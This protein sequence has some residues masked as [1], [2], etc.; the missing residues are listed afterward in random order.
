M[1]IRQMRGLF[2]LYLCVWV[3]SYF[4][5]T[6]LDT[7][8]INK[9]L[10]RVDKLLERNVDSAGI[11][12][13]H[14]KDLCLEKNYDLGAAKSLLQVCRYYTLK[15][16]VDSSLQYLPQAIKLAHKTNDTT[17]IITSYLFYARNLATNSK[18]D[19]AISQALIAQKFSENQKNLKLKTKVYHD[20]GFIHSAMNLH[21]KAIMYFEKGLGISKANKDTFNFANISARLGGEFHYVKLY[22]SS[23]Y[24]NLQGLTY[25]KMLNHKRGIGASMVNLASSYSA[26]HQTD[27][28]IEITKEAIK[29]RIE[30]GDS[31]AVTMLK[32]NLTD[33]YYDKQDYK[34]ALELAK[35]CEILVKEQNESELIIQ[36]YNSLRKIYRK[37]N[38][39]ELAYTYSERYIK[40]KD[41]IFEAANFKTLNELQAKYESEKNEREIKFLQAENESK[42]QQANNERKTRNLMVASISVVALLIGIFTLL[43][44]KRFK[45]T[46]RQ[47]GIIERQKELVDEK[48]REVT[49]S[50]NYAL[51]IQQAVIPHENDL[52]EGIKNAMVVFK[53]K[54]IVSGDFYW[55]SKINQYIFYVV[56]DCTGH[57]VPGAFMSLM[58]INY[59]SEIINEKT[60]FE[61]NDILDALRKKVIVNLNKT[62]STSQKRDGMDLAIFRFNTETMQVQ[63]S[64]ANNAIYV[65]QDGELKELKGDKMP[66]G[67]HSGDD[68]PFTKKEITLK[69]GDRIFSFTDGL[70]DQF[71][72]PKGKK[73]MYK[74]VEKFILQN[75]QKP[76]SELKLVI[77]QEFKSWKGVLEQVDDITFLAVQV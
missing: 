66:I 41:S 72:G 23:L 11:W 69:S 52:K 32:A 71:G 12:A 46:Q 76:L 37:L 30:L 17:L 62:N 64:G 29:L 21:H 70:P 63:F 43:L 49:D 57:G 24:Y 10:K 36:N 39:N 18:Y 27:K 74:T 65:L 44:F 59:L 38:N 5:Q 4:A 61:T 68:K 7:S 73:L 50:I 25:F 34:K 13:K 75:N 67:L 60:I 8:F 42:E 77:E 2:F 19:L 28:A 31:Y 1:N 45:V 6:K 55:H 58:G 47:K 35:E 26:L 40:Y 20:L 15:G 33:C 56:G 54:D 9:E 22:D 51:T 48:N 53:P 3:S 16:K 14:Y